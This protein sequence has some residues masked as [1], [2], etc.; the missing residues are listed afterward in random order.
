MGGCAESVHGSYGVHFTNTHT[1]AHTHTH[2]D[3]HMCFCVLRFSKY[4]RH[5]HPAAASTLKRG[6]RNSS[7]C[8]QAG[9]GRCRQVQAGAGRCRQAGAGGCRQVQAG[10]CRQVQAPARDPGARV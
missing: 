7:I 5:I 2:S 10:R 8:R 6:A 4:Y 3:T 1:H 9:A